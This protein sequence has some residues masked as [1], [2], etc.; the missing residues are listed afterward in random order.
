MAE[1]H[2]MGLGNKGCKCD[3]GKEYLMNYCGQTCSCCDKDSP[4]QGK[5]K[6]KKMK[7]SEL[8]QLIRESIQ[9]LMNE[10]ISDNP[11]MGNTNPNWQAAATAWDMW[12]AENQGGAPQP[13]SVFLNNMQGRS[14]SFYSTRLTAQLDAF[15]NQFGGS[16]GQAGSNNPAWQSQKYAR[17]MWLANEVQQCNPSS[18]GGLGPINTSNSQTATCFSGF[19]NNI[20]NDGPLA[21][22]TC[23][24]GNIALDASNISAMKFRLQSTSNCT[25]LNNK[26]N[27]IQSQVETGCN[28][29][30]KQLKFDYMVALKNNCC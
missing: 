1:E 17:I 20:S 6:I 11:F 27:A 26:I 19:L 5:N 18:G 16:F 12:N 30:R 25:E 21:T 7:K 9:Q 2:K 29:T 13:D 10:Q 22:A 24:N 23:S 15:V 14:C 28:I 8:R 3:D 4:S